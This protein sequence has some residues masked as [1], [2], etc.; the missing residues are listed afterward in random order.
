[1]K[2]FALLV[3]ILLLAGCAG[4]EDAKQ[5]AADAQAKLDEARR[6]AQEAKDR[7]DRVRSATVVREEVVNVTLTPVVEEGELSFVVNASRAGVPLPRE[8]ITSL[9]SVELSAPGLVV[10]CDPADCRATVPPGGWDVRWADG[11]GGRIHAP[12]NATLTR[13]RARAWV[14]TAVGDVTA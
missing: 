6:E 10:T 13:E 12:G 4:V 9:Q 8:N 11:E 14:T 2:G 7:Y 1:M 3:P 5:A